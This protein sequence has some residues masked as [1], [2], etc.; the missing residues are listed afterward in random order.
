MFTFQTYVDMFLLYLIL[1]FTKPGVCDY[2]QDKV[3]GREVPPILYVQN[4][5]LITELDKSTLSNNS[6]EYQNI[7]KK[8]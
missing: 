6:L 1:R 2:Q 3:L 4:K 5:Q 8:A 7:N